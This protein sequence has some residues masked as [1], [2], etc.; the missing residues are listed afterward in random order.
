MT[1]LQANDDDDEQTRTNIHILCGI[2]PH[3]LS[4]QV[5]KAYDS[6]TEAT[7]TD[8][9]TCEC[10]CVYYEYVKICTLKT[11]TFAKNNGDL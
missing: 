4:G 9:N 8:T 11:A 7:V 10:T 1:G 5:I 2:R 3:V 6:D